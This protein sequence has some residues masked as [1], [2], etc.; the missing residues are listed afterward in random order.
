MVA[1]DRHSSY[2]F[3]RAAGAPVRRRPRRGGGSHCSQTLIVFF[4]SARLNLSRRYFGS[5]ILAKTTRKPDE[6]L[7]NLAKT[8]HMPLQSCSA[9]QGFAWRCVFYQQ[10]HARQ[11]TDAREFG[12]FCCSLFAICCLLFGVQ[13]VELTFPK[14]FNVPKHHL[15]RRI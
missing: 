10:R 13:R 7:A 9:M 4:F 8:S 5:E 1:T 11:P 15:Y 14:L 3:L 6:N 12:S 2:Q